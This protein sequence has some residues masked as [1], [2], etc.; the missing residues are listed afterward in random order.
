MNQRAQVF[1]QDFFNRHL[2]YLH[3][4]VHRFVFVHPDSPLSISRAG[5][6]G[7]IPASCAVSI[8]IEGLV[9]N[10]S[11]RSIRNSGK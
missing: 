7:S 1:G 9:T 4:R 11:R 10:I 2:G 8:V 6:C 5:S 3:L